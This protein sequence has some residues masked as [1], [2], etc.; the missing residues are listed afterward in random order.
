[1]LISILVKNT[2][3]SFG[4]LTLSVIQYQ[5]LSQLTFHSPSS[6]QI[7]LSTVGNG[8]CNYDKIFELVV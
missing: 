8:N 6:S 2:L 5:N 4:Y 3:I 1:M 7:A